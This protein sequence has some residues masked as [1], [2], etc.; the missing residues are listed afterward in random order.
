[1]TTDD[2]L[3]TIK[4]IAFWY[5]IAYCVFKL[6]AGCAAS[7]G[8]AT[9]EDVQDHFRELSCVEGDA[10]RFELVC[11]ELIPDCVIE[12]SDCTAA[13]ECRR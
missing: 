11:A 9:C 13:R 4:S 7:H 6:V 10:D 12:A 8:G 5:M 3:F 1:M 2:F